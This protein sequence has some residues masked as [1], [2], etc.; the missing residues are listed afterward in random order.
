MSVAISI[1]SI[2]PTEHLMRT[3]R[4]TL[5]QVNVLRIDEG[6]PQARLNYLAPARPCTWV[7]ES[8][9]HCGKRAAPRPAPVTRSP[10]VSTS[11]GIATRSLSIPTQ[12][13]LMLIS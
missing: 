4:E 12:C 9:W 8:H 1:S 3:Q 5:V 13:S 7:Q 2:V 10:L 11:L 6:A